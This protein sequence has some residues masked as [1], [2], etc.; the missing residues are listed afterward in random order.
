MHKN[1][2]YEELIVQEIYLTK[3]PAAH[4]EDKKSTNL[5]ESDSPSFFN[6]VASLYNCVG[7]KST[8][9]FHQRRTSLDKLLAQFNKTIEESDKFKNKIKSNDLPCTNR[10]KSVPENATIRQEYIEYGKQFCYRGE[11]HGPYYYAY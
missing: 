9:L 1:N 2:F 3:K 4:S 5:N 7:W 10:A 6:E 8:L 11:T